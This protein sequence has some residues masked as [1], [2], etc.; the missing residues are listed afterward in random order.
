MNMNHFHRWFC[1]SA[2]WYRLVHETIV[3]EVLD[4]HDVTL[5]DDVL[6]LGPGP[7][8]T[9]D[10]LR[11]RVD[12]LTAL[13]FDERLHRRL[14]NRLSGEA[15]TTVV[16]GD[17]TAMPFEDQRYSA[18][19]CFTMLHHIPTDP[20]QDRLFA[21]ARRVLRPGG[22]FTGSDSPG[23]HWAFK[24]IHLNDVMNCIDPATLK[25]RLEAAGFQDVEVD[26][27][28]RFMWRAYAA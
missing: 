14:A 6:E 18:V 8:V 21:E 11:K 26:A 19:V 12:R 7:G 10:M 28:D 20:L 4:E 24:A 16:R 1:S 17:A 13:E 15:N 9:T 2:Y 27:G 5:G 25:P 3:P 22:I 23:N